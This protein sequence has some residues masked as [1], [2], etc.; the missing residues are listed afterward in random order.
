MALCSSH[1]ICHS[2]EISISRSASFCGVKCYF[3]PS[4]PD[5]SPHLD[6]AIGKRKES[7]MCGICG[8][9]GPGADPTTIQRMNRSL[10]HRGP[11]G[12]G[13]Y[14]GDGVMLG[15]R[16]LSI[17]DLVTGEQP[18]TNEDRTVWVVFN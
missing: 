14:Q 1:A 10:A 9:V 6:Q 18:M 15:H 12:E 3:L 16:R 7:L 4:I 5:T 13:V 11:D 2:Q 17:I 8:I